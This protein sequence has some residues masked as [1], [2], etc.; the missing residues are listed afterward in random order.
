MYDNYGYLI[1]SAKGTSWEKKNHKYKKR[2][3][4]NGVWKYVYFNEKDLSEQEKRK[5]REEESRLNREGTNY[6]VRTKADRDREH[7]QYMKDTENSRYLEENARALKYTIEP[8][9]KDVYNVRRP[10]KTWRLPNNSTL[11]DDHSVWTTDKAGNITSQ[12]EYNPDNDWAV[13]AK[14]SPKYTKYRRK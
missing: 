9:E 3:K 7:E 11:A 12:L 2:V 14:T 1:H 4:V 5:L 8:K 6:N 13:A 10:R